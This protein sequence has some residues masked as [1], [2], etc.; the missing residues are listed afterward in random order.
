MC[1]S[2]IMI[3]NLRFQKFCYNYNIFINR[4]F[5][6]FGISNLIHFFI[7]VIGDEILK[8]QTLDINTH[9][10][11]QN[12]YKLGIKVEKVLLTLFWLIA[13]FEMWWLLCFNIFLLNSM[14]LLSL[15]K[16]FIL[17]YRVLKIWYN[18]GLCSLYINMKLWKF[19]IF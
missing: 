17:L 16:V 12:L 4:Q 18:L 10:L 9:F 7:S 8:G 19:L 13:Y 1:I 2:K 5:F 14:T 3:V 6:L 11:T 15:V